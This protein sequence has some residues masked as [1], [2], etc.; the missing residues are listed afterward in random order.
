MSLNLEIRESYEFSQ[1]PV[2][3]FMTVAD[4]Y[5]VEIHRLDPG[6][7]KHID[8]VPA[9]AVSPRINQKGTVC[10]NNIIPAAQDITGVP[11]LPR[12]SIP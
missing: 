9:L 8:Q 5:K 11:F 10:Q 7:A 1:S 2:M 12:I 4:Q 6:Q 3:V